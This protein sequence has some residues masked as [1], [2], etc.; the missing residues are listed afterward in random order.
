MLSWVA[1]LVIM[2]CSSSSFSSSPFIPFKTIYSTLISFEI[3]QNKKRTHHCHG[4]CAVHVGR[5]VHHRTRSIPFIWWLFDMLLMCLI[6]WHLLLCSNS[7]SSVDRIKEMRKQRHRYLPSIYKTNPIQSIWFVLQPQPQ[8][9]CF[10]GECCRFW[11]MMIVLKGPLRREKHHFRLNDWL[12]SLCCSKSQSLIADRP[13]LSQLRLVIK[14]H[15][16]IF[17]EVK[18]FHLVY[19]IG[20]II[21]IQNAENVRHWT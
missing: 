10:G 18:L 15:W 19:R 8:Q 16:S 13:R 3:I 9:H 17:F 2:H 14:T 1:P 6:F 11:W 4:T 12:F 21:S 7:S 20:E 5:M